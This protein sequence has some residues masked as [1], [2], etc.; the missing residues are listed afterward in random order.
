VG[1]AQMLG[2][3]QLWTNNFSDAMLLLVSFCVL[4]FSQIF[5]VNW[6]PKVSARAVSVID[7]DTVTFLFS[8]CYGTTSLR[9]AV[10]C[11]SDLS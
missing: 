10:C 6:V 7:D 4:G 2:F 3:K 11:L 8:L 5:V 9:G 1:V